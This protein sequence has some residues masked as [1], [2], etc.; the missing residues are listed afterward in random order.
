MLITFL[1]RVAFLTRVSR[2]F[3]S[4]SVRKMREYQ[5]GKLDHEQSLVSYMV[6]KDRSFTVSLAAR[7]SEEEKKDCLWLV[8]AGVYA[9]PRGKGYYKEAY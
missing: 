8:H 6:F 5:Y 7:C 2:S 9:L 3:A 1:G 4:S